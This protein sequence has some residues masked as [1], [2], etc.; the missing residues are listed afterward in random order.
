M[1]TTELIKETDAETAAMSES[2]LNYTRKLATE[3]RLLRDEVKVLTEA[4]LALRT[5]IGE[6]RNKIEETVQIIEKEGPLLANVQYLDDEDYIRA[7]TPVQ[8]PRS[9]SLRT[10]RFDSSKPFG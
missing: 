9:E 10:G 8:Q 3:V 5:R 6:T 2:M 4:N 1:S 7:S